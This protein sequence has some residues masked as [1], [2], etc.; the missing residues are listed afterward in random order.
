[1]KLNEIIEHANYAIKAH[2]NNAMHEE[3][4]MFDIA[5]SLLNFNMKELN[6]LF[7]GEEE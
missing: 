7:Q 5:V 6:R 1:M 2:I 3:V 4:V